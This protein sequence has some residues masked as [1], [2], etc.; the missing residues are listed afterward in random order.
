MQ[1]R[2]PIMPED[3]VVSLTKAIQRREYGILP[4]AIANVKQRLP[5]AV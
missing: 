1:G 2:V 3:D 5:I 4:E